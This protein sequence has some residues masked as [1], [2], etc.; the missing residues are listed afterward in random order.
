MDIE[1]EQLIN[2]LTRIYIGNAR[3]RGVEI[4][5]I[6]VD[7]IGDKY[8]ATVKSSIKTATIYQFKKKLSTESI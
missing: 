4:K 3:D 2:H 6:E 1:T 7:W 8:E 5:S